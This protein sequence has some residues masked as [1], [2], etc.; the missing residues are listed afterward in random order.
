MNTSDEEFFE[1]LKTVYSIL[2]TLFASDVSMSITDKGKYV[3]V[4]QAET[5]KLNINEGM[6]V[7]AGGV[8]EIAI[9]TGH[10]QSIHYSKETFGFPITA[11]GIPVINPSTKNVVG[12][13]TYAISLQKEIELNEM[14]NE[15]QAF[16]E[17]LAAS[18][19]ELAASTQELATN[20][21]N[22]SHLV[23][24][25]QS[26]ITSMDGI[27]SYIKSIAD[28]TNLLGLNAAIEAARAGEHGIGFNVVAGEIR[29]LA[30]NSKNSTGQVS[31]ALA[32]IKINTNAIMDVLSKFSVTSESQAAQAEQ[33]ASGSQ[34]LSEVS[35]N[36]LN[37]SENMNK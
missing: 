8:S 10:R 9:K 13:I 1:A 26:S 17:E 33:I 7:V 6:Q 18:S 11:Y 24:E 19:E 30:T 27:I 25:T 37:L 23:A 4:K 21:Q 20:S 28:T 29:K 16:S 36:L 14:A 32:K 35:G 3:F 34:R 5:F 15:L 12:T 2:P 31:E 22:V